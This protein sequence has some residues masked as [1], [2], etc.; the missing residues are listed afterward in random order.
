MAAAGATCRDG[1]CEE[2]VHNRDADERVGRGSRGDVAASCG[3]DS[4][5]ENVQNGD[6]CERWI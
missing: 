4:G 5:E 1:R 2:E 3:D 6:A